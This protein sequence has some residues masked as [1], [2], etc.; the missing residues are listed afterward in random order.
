MNSTDMY[1]AQIIS[2]ADDYD[3]TTHGLAELVRDKASAEARSRS[4]RELI[5]LA[6]QLATTLRERGEYY[7]RRAGMWREGLDRLQHDTD[8]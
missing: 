1:L 7:S 2:L 4:Y 3:Q 6:D 5:D 8:D